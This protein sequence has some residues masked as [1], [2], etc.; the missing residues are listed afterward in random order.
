MTL[1]QQINV[2]NAVGTWLAGI[3][4][5]AAVVVS[6]YLARK[7][8][9]LRVKA[10]AGLRQVFA[11]DGTPAEEHVQISVVNHGDRTVIVNSVGWKIGVSK[12]A[13]YCIQP[14]SGNWTQ[15]YP[16]QLAHGETGSFLVSCQAT[17]GWPAQFA[18]GFIR[19]VSPK[20]LKTL[21]ALV[22]TSLGETV[23]VVPEGAL[24]QKLREAA[25]SQVAPVKRG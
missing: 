25:D 22:H 17:P 10:T 23:E 9:R 14:V 6:L 16:K 13:R 24:L 18:K 15:D 2:W 4:T 3:A 12:N 19:D 21:R 1:D 11:G 5:F 20:N 7:S 8:E